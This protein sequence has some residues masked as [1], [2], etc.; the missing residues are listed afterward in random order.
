MLKDQHFGIEIEMTGITRKRAAEVIAGYFDKPYSYVGG[1]Y[2]KYTVYDTNY[3]A[4][5]LVSDSSIKKEIKI[6]GVIESIYDMDYSVELVS[7][8]CNYDD[9][10]TI[11]EIIRKIR[12]AGGFCNDSTGIH[13]HID[14]AP[15][16]ASSLKNLV[17]IFYS[18]EDLLFKALQVKNNR[19]N[20]YCSKVSNAFLERINAQRIDNLERVKYLW[21]NGEDRSCNHYDNSRYHALN[22]HSVFQK[23][24]VEFRMFNSTMHAGKIKAY[25]QLCLAM[26]S[27]A[28]T[29][30]RARY[31]KTVSSNEKYTFRTWLLRLGMIGDEFKTARLHLLE[32]L[33]G[34]IAWKDASQVEKQKQR[35]AQRRI[36]QEQQN[37][38]MESNS[39]DIT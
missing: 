17:N 32:H 34:N 4:W 3:R 8:V 22:L 25:I 30:K 16:D 7:P 23:G 36:E 10:E 15:F 35:L 20:R 29:Q 14:A 19:E 2:D 12:K 26:S 1:V 9:I 38:S 39:L 27:Q 31:I 21:Y 28:L 13:V 6:D 5:N 37:N 11:Q 33:E 24:T 18:K